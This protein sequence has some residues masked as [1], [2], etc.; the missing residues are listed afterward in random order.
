M[1]SKFG[2]SVVGGVT[3]KQAHLPVAKA[4]TIS[5]PVS[6]NQT[7]IADRIKSL[8]Q[9]VQNGTAHLQKLEKNTVKKAGL[10]SRVGFRNKFANVAAMSFAFLLLAGFFTY[11]NI[12]ALEMKVA[13][14]KSGVEARMPGYKPSGY[15]LAGTVK[16]EPGK[17]TVGFV[18]RTDSSKNFT[19]TQQA[20]NWNSSSLLANHVS[21]NNRPYQS[22]QDG[23]KTIYIYDNS[24]AT[25]VDKGIWYQ[26]EG[27]AQLS[28]DQLLRIA[29]SF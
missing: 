17:V 6:S 14:T 3:K 10:L 12:A 29:N 19:V 2:A 8:E 13:A 24:N 21:T 26:V 11:Q 27:N 7:Q 20:S 16:S 18:S 15:G 23:G 22:F 5:Q 28:S 4:A 9:A 1:I 25:W